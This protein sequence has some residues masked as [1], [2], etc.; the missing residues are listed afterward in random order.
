M[1]SRII[2]VRLKAVV[3]SE[4]RLRIAARSGVYSLIYLLYTPL[5]GTAG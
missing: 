5:V 1:D 4:V 3:V 2:K